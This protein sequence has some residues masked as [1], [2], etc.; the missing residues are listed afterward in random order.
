M[1]AVMEI[2][3]SGTWYNDRRSILKLVPEAARLSGTFRPGSGAYAGEAFP[4]HGFATGSEVG[5]LVAFG[6]HGGVTA[7]VGHVVTLAERVELELLWHMAL[8]LTPREQMD[9]WRGV[10]AGLDRFR[11]DVEVAPAG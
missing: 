1:G 5:F 8:P 9:P 10:W 11:R 4:V 2:D 3:L 7:W 6:Q